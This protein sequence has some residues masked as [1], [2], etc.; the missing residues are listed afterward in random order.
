[1]SKSSAWP[2]KHAGWNTAS[3]NK[4]TYNGKSA[5]SAHDLNIENI[6]VITLTYDWIRLTSTLEIEIEFSILLEIWG[7]ANKQQM[8]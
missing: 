3:V 8:T 4:M 6:M 1:M 5:Q 2:Q 7:D